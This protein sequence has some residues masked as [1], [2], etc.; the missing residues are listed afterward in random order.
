MEKIHI[1]FMKDIR[2]WEFQALYQMIVQKMN[3][4]QPEEGDIKTSF[5]RILPHLEKMKYAL[6]NRSKSKYSLANKELTAQRNK[7]LNMLHKRVQSYLP[8]Y[9]PEESEAAKD[10]NFILR[11]FDKR[12]F[13]AT[14]SRQDKMVKIINEDI[15][16]NESYRDALRVLNLNDMIDKI[17]ILTDQIYLNAT[18]QNKESSA[19]KRSR[20][21]VRNEA[22]RDLRVMINT[23]NLAFYNNQTYEE[24][25][26]KLWS[27]V[28]IINDTLQSIQ[29]PRKSR[30]TKLKNKKAA[31][32]EKLTNRQDEDNMN[33]SAPS[34][35][36]LSVSHENGAAN[37]SKDLPAASP[38]YDTP[39][40][41]TK[42]G[43]VSVENSTS[44][45]DE[46]YM[47]TTVRDNIEHTA[48][49]N[50]SPKDGSPNE[51][52]ASDNDVSSG[53]NVNG[54][55]TQQYFVS[56]NHGL[57]VKNKLP[58]HKSSADNTQRNNILADNIPENNSP[59][60]DNSWGNQNGE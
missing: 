53:I 44:G 41:L 27:L 58:M 8:S 52:I 14:I 54:E 51:H 16:T 31:A 46:E 47:E 18:L 40:M 25:D 4:Y 49:V 13:V 34:T 43:P 26:D 22:F 33:A 57:I 28:G 42:D 45:K 6:Q 56:N 11:Q 21:G 19:S 50:P 24:Q 32:L 20:E 37:A 35:N 48:S 17:N 15:K 5:E 59:T 29:T 38:S 12:Y 7:L 9:L 2:N 30:I 55:Q 1:G 39:H 60:N 36:N 3:W 23:I 10:L